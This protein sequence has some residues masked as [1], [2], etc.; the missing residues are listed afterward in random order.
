MNKYRNPDVEKDILENK[1]V[2]VANS[3]H[4]EN[5]MYITDLVIELLLTHKQLHARSIIANIIL[6]SY[7]KIHEVIK[8]IYV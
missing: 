8:N 6:D 7:Q 5:T 4:L 1:L 3:K 2:A